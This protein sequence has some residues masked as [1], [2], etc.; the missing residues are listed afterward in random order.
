MASALAAYR[1]QHPK[2]AGVALA[3]VVRLSYSVWCGDRPLW[4]PGAVM[5]TMCEARPGAI[6]TCVVCLRHL[7]WLVV[8][9]TL[10][11][12]LLGPALEPPRLVL[13]LG[14]LER[15]TWSR[16]SC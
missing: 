10:V 11:A 7:V 4:A 3:C 5:G 1:L 6:L 15:Q 16:C 13:V 14:G 8:T 12:D 9:F 2:A